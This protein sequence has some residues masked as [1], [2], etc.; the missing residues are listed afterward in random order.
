MRRDWFRISQACLAWLWSQT[1]VQHV[2]PLQIEKVN[3]LLSLLTDMSKALMVYRIQVIRKRLK[4]K[5]NSTTYTPLTNVMRLLIE[6]GLL[7]TS[8]IVIL[9]ILYMS[10]NNGQ[11]G[12]SNAVSTVFFFFRSPDADVCSGCSDHCELPNIVHP[13]LCSLWLFF[14]GHHLQPNHHSGWPWRSNST[15][16]SKYAYWSHRRA[17]YDQ[18]PDNSF[19]LRWPY[20]HTKGCYH[21][22]GCRSTKRRW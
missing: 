12:V 7:Y 5:S 9:F 19:S 15:S 2:S 1:Y 22:W 8:S 17:A 3:Y 16:L 13:S 10:S 21:R 20:R 14:S 6:S 11:Y 4:H 18:H